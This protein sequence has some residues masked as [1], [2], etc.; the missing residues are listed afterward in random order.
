[1]SLEAAWLLR[2]DGKAE[3]SIALMGQSLNF[4]DDNCPSIGKNNEMARICDFR[5]SVLAHLRQ[6]EETLDELHRM[7]IEERKLNFPYFSP[8]MGLE[9]LQGE[10]E[11]EVI[12]Q[13]LD[14]QRS[15]QLE[16]VREM[17]RNGEMPPPPW[18]KDSS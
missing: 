4:L 17:D 13:S 10:P 16:H 9:F 18:E 5:V 2:A 11:F 6:R 15:V 7:I 14:E 8:F 1:M 12:L 3:K